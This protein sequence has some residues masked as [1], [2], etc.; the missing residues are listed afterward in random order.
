MTKMVYYHSAYGKSGD[1]KPSDGIKL[2][3]ITPGV[4][5]AYVMV[6]VLVPVC[7]L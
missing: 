7:I 4:W 3:S 2:C 6:T 1:D 5:I